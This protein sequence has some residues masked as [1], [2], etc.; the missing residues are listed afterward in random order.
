MDLTEEIVDI[1]FTKCFFPY[2]E[3]IRMSTTFTEDNAPDV[4]PLIV[5]LP[6]GINAYAFRSDELKAN[7]A[8]IN[9]LVDQINWVS[10]DYVLPF[11]KMMEKLDGTL[12]D[13]RYLQNAK[14]LCF[15]YCIRFN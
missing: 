14:T 4:A 3:M 15:S 8:I 9:E 11:F 1:I 10:Y 2:E 6:S 13:S 5:A 7:K 12:L